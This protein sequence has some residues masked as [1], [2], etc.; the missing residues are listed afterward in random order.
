[1]SEEIISIL[2]HGIEM[3]KKGLK[4][5]LKFARR[6]K[7]ETGKNMFIILASDEADH[8]QILE[9]QLEHYLENNSWRKI[10]IDESEIE[11]VISKISEL[12][13]KK[14]EGGV[15]QVDALRIAMA[16]EE[17]AIEFYKQG[18]DK[19][20]DSALKA[21]FKELIDME[22]AHY[23]LQRAELDSVEGNSYWFD[24]PEF[25]LEME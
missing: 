4:E 12:A 5:Y 20:D 22:D 21:M 14:G 7:N 11:K 24:I 3:E 6:T 8:V 17:K 23:K 16:M 2:K 9:D 19:A 13:A 10:D 1:M 25:S 18:Y 15:E